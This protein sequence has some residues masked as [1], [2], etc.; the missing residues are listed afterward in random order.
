MGYETKAASQAIITQSGKTTMPDYSAQSW[1]WDHCLWWERLFLGPARSTNWVFV[2][3]EAKHRATCYASCAAIWW[4]WLQSL[5]LLSR[6]RLFSGVIIK[7]SLLLQ[8]HVFHARTKHIWVS[9][10][11]YLGVSSWDWSIVLPR[12][13]QQKFSPNRY[14]K[15]SCCT[16]VI[17]F[18]Y[19]QYPMLGGGVSTIC[20]SICYLATH[21]V[22]FPLGMVH[23]LPTFHYLL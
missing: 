3:R 9:L 12:T 2:S 23:L 10:P 20:T 18:E 14:P 11:L 1:S 8:S 4:R 21:F 6:D 5:D 16:S 19:S 17:L 7:V 13:M 15:V 22:D